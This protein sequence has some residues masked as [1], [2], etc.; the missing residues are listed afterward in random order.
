MYI[1]LTHFRCYENA[2]FDFGEQGLVLLSGSSGKGKS[3]I[4]MAIDFVL[5]GNGTKIITH[6][7]KS[8]TVE[9]KLQDLKVVR[10][11][12]PN[13]LIVN[14]LY[15][16]AAGEAVINA[17]FG[18]IFNSVSYIPQNLK[19]S[20]VLMSSTDRLEFLETFAFNN[21]DILS[22]KDRAKSLIRE[23]NDSLSKTIGKLQFA[24]ELFLQN[25]F[26]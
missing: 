12:G 25:S 2:E 4:L 17:K 24:N 10:K 1:K 22:L 6:G 9:F 18:K 20:F 7:K 15:E 16:D 26:F 19:K 14:D 5:F 13:H 23:N 21:F 3:T 8:C 11:K